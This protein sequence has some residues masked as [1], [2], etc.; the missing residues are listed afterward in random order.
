VVVGLFL[1]VVPG[2]WLAGCVTM[3][4]EV[5]AIDGTG[6]LESIRRCLTVVRGRWWPTVGFVLVVG[7]LG[8]AA[9][10][11]VQFVALPALAEGDVGIV[12]GLAFVFL[13]V[14]QG[15]VAAAI[16]VMHARWYIDLRARKETVLTTHL[17]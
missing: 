8:A 11:L 16:G 9:A 6:P 3:M 2:G 1:L 10:Q 5:V 13:M 12:A 7:L 14:V 4:P 15:F 17:A